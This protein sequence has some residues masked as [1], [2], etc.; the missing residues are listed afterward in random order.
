VKTA[1]LDNGLDIFVVERRELPK[2]SVTLATRAGSV[3]DPDGKGGLS[4]MTAR[5]MRRARHVEGRHR[6]R[7][8]ARQPRHGDRMGRGP[9]ARAAGARGAQRNLAPALAIL[10]DVARNPAFPA[11]EFDREQK[12]ALDALAQMANTPAAV[13]NRVAFMLAFGLDHPYGRPP[14]VCRARCPA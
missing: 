11:A 2:V 6:D 10:A 5:V 8:R 4:S 12:L 14:P 1:K 7:Y 13:A 3:S 9:R